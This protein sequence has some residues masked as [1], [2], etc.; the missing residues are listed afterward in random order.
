MRKLFFA[1]IVFLAATNVQASGTNPPRDPNHYNLI[2]GVGAQAFDPVAYFPEGGG[3]PTPG[4][5]SISVDY[6]GV[7]Y[8]FSNEAHRELFNRQPTK[9]EPAYGGWC[10]LVMRNATKDIVDPQFFIVSGNRLF[11]FHN[12]EAKS[13][14]ARDVVKASRQSDA[15]WKQVSGENPRK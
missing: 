2:Q 3:T 14:F 5:Q 8:Y 10:S 12:E 13:L 7:I 15:G 11:L 1:G 6:K 9:Y 4:L